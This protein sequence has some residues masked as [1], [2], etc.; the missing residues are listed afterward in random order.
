M[1]VE[2]DVCHPATYSATMRQILENSCL[3]KSSATTHSTSCLQLDGD[4]TRLSAADYFNA[5]RDASSRAARG[6]P[7]SRGTS[8]AGVSRLVACG[9]SATHEEPHGGAEGGGH[10]AVE[11]AGRVD[12]DGVVRHG[13]VFRGPHGECRAWEEFS[14]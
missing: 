1:C 2:A 3:F 13:R 7:S 9:S 10:E 14:G 8:T 12:V 5:P 6:R 11:R 4:S